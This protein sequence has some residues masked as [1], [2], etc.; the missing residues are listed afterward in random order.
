MPRCFLLVPPLLAVL[1]GALSAAEPAEVKY[2]TPAESKAAYEKSVAPFLAKHCAECHNAKNAKGDL[3]LTALD[4][5]MKA[6]TS[7]AR[8][9]MVVEKLANGEMPPKS[10]PRPADAEL[11]A[12]GQWAHAEAKRAG[13]PFTRRAAYANGNAVPHHVLFD[14]KNIPPFDG[15]PRVRRLSPEI[16][17]AFTNDL[18]KGKSDISQP[19]S[20]EG[21]STFKD[22]GAPKI[23]EPVTAQLI[24]NALAIVEVQTNHKVED[25]QVKAV[26]GTPKEFLALLDPKNPPT[27]AQIEAAIVKQFDAILRRAP[28]ADEKKKFVAFTKK[29]IADAGP[30]VGTRYALAAVLLLPEAVLRMEVGAGK[31]DAKGRVRLSPREIAF[32]LSYGLTDKRPDAELLKAAAT[33]ELDTDAGVAKQVRRLLDDPKAEKPRILRFFREYFGYNKADEV[34]KDGIKDFGYDPKVI[35]A[36]T[37]ALVLYVLKQDRDVLK[38][39]LTTD[40]GFVN[41]RI[42]PKKP[43]AVVEYHSKNNRKTHLNYSLPADWQ[44]TAQQPITFP[45]GQRAGILTQPSWLVAQST[46]FDNHAIHRGKWVRERLLGGVVPDVPIT[47]DAQLPDAPHKTLR[48]RMAVTQEKYCWQCHRLMNDVGYPFEQFDH[49]GRFRTGEKVLDPEATAKNKD[50]KGK[51]LGPVMR[52]APLDTTGLIAHLGDPTLEGAVKNVAEYMKRLAGS[53]RVE[54]VFVRH[55]FRYWT[56]RNESPGDAATLQAAH[57]AYKDSTGS[58]KALI[59]SLLSSES[60]LYRVPTPPEPNK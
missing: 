33:G 30:V 24:Q 19:F 8:W 21:K 22:M 9:A 57:K 49:F 23:D 59:V 27:D 60:F 40:K 46:S 20:P 54:Q 53:E 16:Y 28:T 36:D 3:D 6:T 4:P 37:D 47:V 45:D 32:A 31:P 18:A 38:E 48:E 15:D 56:G 5:D 34:F 39:L 2:A 26:G 7:G 58:M 42:D 12:V 55:T 44:W 52:D 43:D 35:I 29:N 14:P 41:A 10:K 17:A 13:R 11:V 1:V 25:G 51:P 50:P